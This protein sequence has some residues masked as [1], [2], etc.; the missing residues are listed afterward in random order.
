MIASGLTKGAMMLVA[1]AVFSWV[2]AD[3]FQHRAIER[4]ASDRAIYAPAPVYKSA[5]A[6]GLRAEA[7]RPL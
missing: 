3:A 1:G 6:E 7:S 4:M 2:L 5:F